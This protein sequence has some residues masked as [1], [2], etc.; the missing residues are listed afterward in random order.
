MSHLIYR[1]LAEVKGFD[2]D[3]NYTGFI[4]DNWDDPLNLIPVVLCILC[5]LSGLPC[6]FQAWWA[7]SNTV[8]FHPMDL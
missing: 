5:L 3:L 6:S 4:I 2:R 8:I 7:L 1:N